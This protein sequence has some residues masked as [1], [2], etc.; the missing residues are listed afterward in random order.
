M[1]GLF[2]TNQ[3][4]TSVDIGDFL[5][6]TSAVSNFLQ[7]GEVIEIEDDLKHS[8]NM[9]DELFK[10]ENMRLF[11]NNKPVYAILLCYIWN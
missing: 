6:F 4:I 11:A 10:P 3:K 1:L 7:E 5:K 2:Y 9:L 8:K